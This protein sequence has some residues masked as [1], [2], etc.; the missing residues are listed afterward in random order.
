MATTRKWDSKWHFQIRQ[1]KE[2]EKPT[3]THKA[4]A[5]TWAR[6]IES[7]IDMDGLN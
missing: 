5:H 3:F 4:D 6:L 7:E 2:P 1:L